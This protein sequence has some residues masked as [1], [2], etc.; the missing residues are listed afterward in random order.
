M[1]L[2]EKLPLCYT[3]ATHVCTTISYTEA[4]NGTECVM[5]IYNT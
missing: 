5:P 4:I 3:C 2:N 1:S